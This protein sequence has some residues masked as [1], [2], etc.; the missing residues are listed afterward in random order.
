MQDKQ[1]L[2][3][4]FPNLSKGLTPMAIAHGLKPLELSLA[5][6]TEVLESANLVEAVFSSL[7]APLDNDPESCICISMDA[8]WNI[9]R[10]IGVSIIQVAPHSDPNSV[11]IIPV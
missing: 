3:T 6:K 8:E 4:A 7:M 1:L 5:L 2:F 9:S 10:T 11:Y